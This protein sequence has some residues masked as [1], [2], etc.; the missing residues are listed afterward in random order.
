MRRGARVAATCA[1]LMS[2]G[3]SVSAV[4]SGALA[5]TN[6]ITIGKSVVGRVM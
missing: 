5:P 6:T 2:V 1:V 4:P 3:G